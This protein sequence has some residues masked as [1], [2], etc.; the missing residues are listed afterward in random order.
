MPPLPSV[1][2]FY[3]EDYQGSPSWFQKFI[4]ALNLFS[5]PMYQNLNKGLSFQANFNAQV[6]SFQIRAGATASDNTVSFTTTVAGKA[7]GVVT[8]ACNLASDIQAPASGV[9]NSWYQSGANIII[10]SI[11][12]LTSGTNY[13]LSVLVF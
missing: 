12:G 5:D 3:N 9:V 2:R 8:V 1:R 4:G 6:Y 10:T 11:S 7:S 13:N